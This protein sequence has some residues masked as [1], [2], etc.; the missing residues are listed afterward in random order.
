MVENA[1]RMQHVMLAEM[2]ALK[3]RHPS[4]LD[5]RA[6][7]LF[8]AID[9]QKDTKGTRMAP[10]GG[11]HPAIDRMMAFFKQ[12]GLF[13]VS[14][15]WTLMCNPPL[16]ITEAELREGFE[17]IDRGLAITDAAVEGA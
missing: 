7:G 17:I 10:Y 5:F 6:I 2:A 1:A 9:L 13:T 8:G 12:E 15:W 11:S 3:A 4:V 16:C 14:H